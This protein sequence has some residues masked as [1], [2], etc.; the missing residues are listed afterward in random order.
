M[1]NWIILTIVSFS[2]ALL[3]NMSM[4]LADEIPVTAGVSSSI[5]ATFDTGYTSIDFGD[6]LSVG[7]S[8]NVADGNGGTYLVSIDTNTPYDVEAALTTNLNDGSTHTIALGNLK[9][10]RVDDYTT[11]AVGSAT[12]VT[13]TTT[14]GVTIASD[15]ADTTTTDYHCFWLSI[16]GAQHAGSYSGTIAITYSASE[17]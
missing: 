9:M 11:C 4:A 15:V 12:S 14:P 10:E 2:I 13:A 5:V 16:P 3:V 7:S 17:V 1:K 8:N 6:A